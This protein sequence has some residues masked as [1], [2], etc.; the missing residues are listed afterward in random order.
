[1]KFQDGN[2]FIQPIKPCDPNR[3]SIASPLIDCIRLGHAFLQIF[4]ICFFSNEFTTVGVL[5]ISLNVPLLLMAETEMTFSCS[6]VSP[7]RSVYSLNNLFSPWDQF[8]R[9]FDCRDA[10]CTK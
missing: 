10:D 5:Q 1:M 4:F 7:I 3:L 8:V 2:R 6:F 9:L